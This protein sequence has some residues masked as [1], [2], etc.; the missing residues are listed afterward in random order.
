MQALL[1]D[2]AGSNIDTAAALVENAGRFLYLL[3]EG[4][5]RMAN[6]LEVKGQEPIMRFLMAA[7]KLAEHQ[8]QMYQTLHASLQSEPLTEVHTHV[9]DG[10]ETTSTECVLSLQG[11]QVRTAEGIGQFYIK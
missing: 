9:V 7:L 6:F 10:D 4:H 11:C 5:T 2:F 3:P 1:D 8:I